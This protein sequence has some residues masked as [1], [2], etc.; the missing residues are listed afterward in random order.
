M[1][2]YNKFDQVLRYSRHGQ[3]ASAIELLKGLLADEPNNA[4][5]HGTLA[6]CLLQ[7][8]RLHAAEYE[9]KIA[10]QLAP[11]EPFL[12]CISARIYYLQNKP[13]EALAACD[14]A[15]QLEPGNVEVFELKSDILIANKKYKEGFSY[16]QQMAEQEPDSIDTLYSFANYYYVIGDNVNAMEFARAGLAVNAEHPGVNVLMGRLHLIN[17]NI[18]EA[19]YHARLTIMLNPNSR[20]AL[21]LFSDVKARKNIFIGIWWKFNTK[22]SRMSTLNQVAVLI[23]GYVFFNLLSIIL[24]D[25]GYSKSSTLVEFSWLAIVIYSWVALPIY[26]R[27]LS[28]EIEQF[29]FR[30]D[31]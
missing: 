11:N 15:L 26:Q 21:Q 22:I 29:S 25:Y 13:N 31:Y 12:H 18:A 30:S 9:L 28:K 14:N 5:Y 4:I 1:N 7:Q 3:V 20:E 6:S 27:M 24:N 23:F 2:N 17:G 19:E 16:I 10:M 8:S